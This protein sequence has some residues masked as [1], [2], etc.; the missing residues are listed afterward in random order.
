M[1]IQFV[2]KP[3]RRTVISVSSSREH[4]SSP[5]TGRQKWA[6]HPACALLQLL[7]WTDRQIRSGKRGAIPKHLAPILQRL[8]M[9]PAFWVDY[10]RQFHKFSR[11]ITTYSKP[12][13]PRTSGQHTARSLTSRN[14]LKGKNINLG[15]LQLPRMPSRPREGG[16]PCVPSNRG[17]SQY[18]GFLTSLPTTSN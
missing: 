11:T 14:S 16:W 4:S 2:P 15:I 18:F 6:I 10:V 12:S 1:E 9:S 13:E 8:G 3:L 7:D 17:L 5:D